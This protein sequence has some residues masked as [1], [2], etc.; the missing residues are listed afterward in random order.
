MVPQEVDGLLVP[1]AMSSSHVAYTAFR[2][3]PIWMAT[4]Q[5]AGNAAAQAIGEGTAVR[6]IDVGKLQHTLVKQRQVLA[7]FNNLPVDDPRFEQVQLAAL[8]EDYPEY[9]AE[10]LL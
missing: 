10:P 2:H 7:W 9:D 8:A 3:E 5:A 1:V 4:G 6:S